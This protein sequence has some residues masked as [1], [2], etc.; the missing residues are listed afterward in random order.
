MAKSPG[1]NSQ[2][3]LLPRRRMNRNGRDV[4]AATLKWHHDEQPAMPPDYNTPSCLG[5]EV[6]LVTKPD[7]LLNFSE[8]KP[9]QSRPVSHVVCPYYH[10]PSKPLVTTMSRFHRTVPCYK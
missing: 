6:A 7:D 1:F 3:D 2:V 9:S 8:I 4:A 10:F 5:V